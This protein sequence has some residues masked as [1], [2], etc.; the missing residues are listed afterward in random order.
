MFITPAWAQA[1]VPGAG[2]PL[3]MLEFAVPFILI[4]VI[5][6][7]FMIRPQQQRQKAHRDM[8]NAVRR[9][10]VVVTSGGLIGKVRSVAD[11]EDEVTVEIAKGVEV[12]VLRSMLADVRSKTEPAAAKAVAADAKAKDGDSGKTS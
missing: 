10:D 5:M 9:G 4:F 8:I 3:G 6:Y 7:F 1:A 11:A 2:S 12:K